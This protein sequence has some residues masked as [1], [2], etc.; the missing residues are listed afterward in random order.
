MQVRTIC[1]AESPHGTRC[2]LRLEHGGTHYD[3]EAKCVWEGNDY[4]MHDG[5]PARPVTGWTEQMLRVSAPCLR[6]LEDKNMDVDGLAEYLVTAIGIPWEGLT[7]Q[8][9]EN[10]REIARE[11]I[12]A[13]REARIQPASQQRA[14]K[15]VDLIHWLEIAQS[16]WGSGEVTASRSGNTLAIFQD[17][18][19]RAG[20]N[21]DDDRP[22]LSGFADAES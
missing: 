5:Y 14:L 8:Q 20:I 13:R 11:K 22:C 4:H 2:S 10:Y 19:Y 7:P 9:Q 6:R 16:R 21:L 1:G 15:L 12:A 17:G 3:R 18:A